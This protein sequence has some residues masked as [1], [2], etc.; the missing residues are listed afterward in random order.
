M[1]HGYNFRAPLQNRVCAST[2]EKPKGFPCQEES[3]GAGAAK[4]ALTLMKPATLKLRLFH[5]ASGRPAA[6]HGF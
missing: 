2:S 4:A 6:A 1:F 5:G 3:F